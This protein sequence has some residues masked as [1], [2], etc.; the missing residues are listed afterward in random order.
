MLQKTYEI[1]SKNNVFFSNP[2][3]IPLIYDRQASILYCV[4]TEKC[5]FDA[6]TLLWSVST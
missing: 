2:L 3:T 5:I 6:H 1:L 4:L